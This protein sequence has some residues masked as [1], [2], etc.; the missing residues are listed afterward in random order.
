MG[1]VCLL[2]RIIL[3]SRI[4]NIILLRAKYKDTKGPYTCIKSMTCGAHYN[5]IV[6]AP[7][8]FP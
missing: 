3:F 8:Q 7:I 6:V 5:N 2:A 1:D 4:V